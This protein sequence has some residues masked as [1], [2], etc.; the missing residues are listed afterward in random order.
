MLLFQIK[1]AS[2]NDKTQLLLK[3]IRTGKWYEQSV[4]HYEK[5]KFE[6]IEN[7]GLVLRG[8]RIFFPAIK[9]KGFDH[10]RLR[11]FGNH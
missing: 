4:K 1:E 8:N 5:L 2:A 7:D 6:V 9:T 10:S 11:S 3:A